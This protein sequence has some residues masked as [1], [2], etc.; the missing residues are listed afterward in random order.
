MFPK[1][2]R[3]FS[4]HSNHLDSDTSL[5]MPRTRVEQKEHIVVTLLEQHTMKDYGVFSSPP[6]LIVEEEPALRNALIQLLSEE[7]YAP[8]GVASLDEAWETVDRRSFALM[9]ADL[10][11]G[12]SP[13]SFTSAH[14]LRRHAPSTPMGIMTDQ[15]VSPWDRQWSAFAFTI[16]KPIE[17]T[18]LLVEVA[19]SLHLPL[20]RE[21]MRQEEIVR[22]LLEAIAARSWRRLLSLCTEDIRYYPSEAFPG[23]TAGPAQGAKALEAFMS[24]VWQNAPRLR[25]EVSNIFSRPRGLALRYLRYAPTADDGWAWQESTAL[26]QF[27]GDYICQIGFPDLAR[28]LPRSHQIPQVG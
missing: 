13:H 14:L 9:L 27:V 20:S 21:Q 8:S 12:R 17:T 10:L 25:L 11:V 26:F 16:P 23:F 24:S 1:C 22:R 7:G 15:A 5:V 28:P 4:P 2:V 6:I 18:R 19:A 3:N